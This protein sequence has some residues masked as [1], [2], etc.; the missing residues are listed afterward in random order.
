MLFEELKEVVNE[1]KDL[2]FKDLEV[3][4]KD[5]DEIVLG[6]ASFELDHIEVETKDYKPGIQVKFDLLEFESSEVYCT[7]SLNASKDWDVKDISITISG[8]RL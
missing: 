7:I 2:E 1:L 5:I 3:L 4:K 8:D 6:T